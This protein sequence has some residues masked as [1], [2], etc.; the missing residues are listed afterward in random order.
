MRTEAVTRI[1]EAV[2]HRCS[3]KKVFCLRPATLLKQRL[4][5]KCF[6]VNFAKFLGILFLTEHLRW[7]LLLFWFWT[8]KT[9]FVYSN[10]LNLGTEAVTWRCYVKRCALKNSQENTCIG[11]SFLMLL[12]CAYKTP[13]VT[14]YGG[15]RQNSCPFMKIHWKT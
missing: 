9:D 12:A 8:A 10:Q 14:I 6:P 3:V 5:H 2:A 7:L 4:S 11:V 15:V 13:L 1:P